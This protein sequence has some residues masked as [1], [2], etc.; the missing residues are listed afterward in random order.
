[1]KIHIH[2]LNE[3]KK[4]YIVWFEVFCLEIQIKTYFKH[5]NYFPSLDLRSTHRIK[6][7]V[8]GLINKQQKFGKSELVV[9]SRA[10]L[11]YFLTNLGFSKCSIQL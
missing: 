2:Y 10:L 4:K 8:Y 7:N 9:A 5:K 6:I 3:M 1:M 11:T